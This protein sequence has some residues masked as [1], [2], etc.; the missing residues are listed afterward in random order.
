MSTTTA[1][2][3]VLNEEKTVAGAQ[4]AGV[5]FTIYLSLLAGLIIVYS[6]HRLFL[7]ANAHT[8][9]LDYFEPE[10][11]VWMNLFYVQ[12]VVLPTLMAG[13]AYYLWRTRELNPDN[14]APEVELSRYFSFIAWL[15]CYTLIVIFAG[16]VHGEADAAWHQVVIRDTDFTPTHVGLFYL[17]M[18]ALIITG[19]GSYIFAKTR[20]PM[21]A[22]Q[23]L[24]PLGV[25]IGGP[26]LIM[27]NVGLNEWGHTF[28]Y[29]EEMFGTPI[30]YGFAILGLALIALGGVVVHIVHR[31]KE[32]VDI[33]SER[34]A[35]QGV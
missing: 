35:R 28:F 26:I 8:V 25:A 33:V 12:I 19:G 9:G 11:Q 4:R 24:L 7:H 3:S 20:L 15:S 14:V 31:C 10:F 1:E 13:I 23:H 2:L 21:H 17:L 30:H 32:L 16:A 5:N 6:L 27:P 34:E 18:P 22:K 29:A